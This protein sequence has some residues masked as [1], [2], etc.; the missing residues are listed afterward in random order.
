MPHRK[1]QRKISETTWERISPDVQADHY[2]REKG[3]HA[4]LAVLS[5]AVAI[6]GHEDALRGVLTAIIREAFLAGSDGK[7]TMKIALDGE[8]VIRARLEQIL[9]EHGIPIPTE[10]MKTDPP[11]ESGK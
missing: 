4:L 8:Q 6:P 3:A 2:S 5:Q 1:K 10:L 7:T 11:P 9:A